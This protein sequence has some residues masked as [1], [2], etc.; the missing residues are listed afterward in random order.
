MKIPTVSGKTEC[1]FLSIHLQSSLLLCCSMDVNGS[2][3]A[4][5][6]VW[7]SQNKLARE[8]C[9]LKFRRQDLWLCRAGF[10]ILHENSLSVSVPDLK[11]YFWNKCW[12]S[13]GLLNF[14][15]VCEG[16]IL[17]LGNCFGTVA[18]SL[19]LSALIC[20]PFGIKTVR[21]LY[22]ILSVVTIFSLQG[23]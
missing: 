19:N 18:I 10:L 1:V 2:C 13:H 22:F 23:I 15:Q 11:V 21:L 8:L 17:A 14:L 5:H 6:L 4:V 7:E 20:S 12:L 16:I 9:P 3:S